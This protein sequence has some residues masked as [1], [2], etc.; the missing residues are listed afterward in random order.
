[1]LPLA[2]GQQGQHFLRSHPREKTCVRQADYEQYVQDLQD[3]GKE[4]Q[5]PLIG[6][7]D[8]YTQAGLGSGTE[9]DGGAE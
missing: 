7:A 2:L 6:A 8:A 9:S 4:S 3:A 5:T 1:M